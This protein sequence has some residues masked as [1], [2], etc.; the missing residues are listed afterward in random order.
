MPPPL[1]GDTEASLI[2]RYM[3]G[4]P[5]F[6]TFAPRIAVLFPSRNVATKVVLTRLVRT[7]RHRS[8]RFDATGYLLQFVASTTNRVQ[9]R[10]VEVLVD[11]AAQTADLNINHIGLRVEVVVPYLSLIHI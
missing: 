9:Q 5:L 1:D 10:R 4:Q 3:P 8:G 2:D 11:F 6:T 7:S